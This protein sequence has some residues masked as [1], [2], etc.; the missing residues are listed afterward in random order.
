MFS[1]R[2]IPLLI[3]LCAC[4][5][6]ADISLSEKSTAPIN[7]PPTPKSLQPLFSLTP[8]NFSTDISLSINA[9]ESGTT[10]YYTLDGSQPDTTKSQ[11][12]TPLSLSG[13]GTTWNVRAI[14]K[15]NGADLSNVV[16]G[17]YIINYQMVGSPTITPSS[18][19]FSSGSGTWNNTVSVT[20]QP[21][22]TAAT[23]RYTTN[24]ADPLSSGTIYSGGSIAITTDGTV[25]K[26]IA[27]QTQMLNSTVTSATVN[28]KVADI[29]IA[30]ASTALD[31][32]AQ[33]SMTTTTTGATIRYTTDG[34][35]PTSV[36]G[37]VYTAPITPNGNISIKALAYRS[38]FQDSAI[39]GKD[40]TVT[41]QA[42]IFSLAAGDY[43][44]AQNLTLSVAD[45]NLA[46]R[47]TTDGSDPTTTSGTVYT[48]PI[49]ISATTQVRAVSFGA[50]YG[51]S[52]PIVSRSY[53][54]WPADTTV[55]FLLSQGYY[56]DRIVANWTSQA[57][58]LSYNLYRASSSNGVYTLLTNTTGFTYSDSTATPG[59]RYYYKLS[60]V[61]AGGEARPATGYGHRNSGGDP[62]EP[63]D[64]A[65][66]AYSMTSGF[67]ITYSLT[68]SD[69]YDTD[70]FRYYANPATFQITLGNLPQG[71]YFLDMGSGNYYTFNAPF[72]GY[73]YSTNF[74][75]ST[76]S[77]YIM[78]FQSTSGV[79]T[80]SPYTLRI[81]CV[82]CP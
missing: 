49:P 31:G 8:G 45:G 64:H 67:G 29:T 3:V 14:A 77:W 32:T 82:S 2:P 34:S 42:P 17:T 21:W 33:I 52:S 62:Y 78:H 73:T 56:L 10:I 70:W 6:S 12:T 55:T 16:S 25:V 61:V 66:L 59:V 48:G 79:T 43:F 11:Y 54:I 50:A 38:S 18:G 65:S 36:H 46:M 7:Q 30:P 28:Y 75:I 15:R 5:G 20:L 63:N 57:G 26:A 53:N 81:F 23:I 68:L 72:N 39:S 13:H 22:P 71:N 24:G 41:A 1:Y 80:S 4:S 69:P 27:T 51:G 74:S 60:A 47:Y 40:Y 35:T 58:A 9:Q 19:S 44:S 76:S 37:T